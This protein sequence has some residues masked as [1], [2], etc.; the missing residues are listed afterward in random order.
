[1][2]RFEFTQFPVECR[3]NGWYED[4]SPDPSLLDGVHEMTYGLEVSVRTRED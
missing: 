3:E 4:R 1:M 2:D